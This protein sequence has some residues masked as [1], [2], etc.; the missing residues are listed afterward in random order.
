MPKDDLLSWTSS[1]ENI[2]KPPEL[3]QLFKEYPKTN[4]KYCESLDLHHG[5]I[6]RTLAAARRPPAADDIIAG[7]SVGR[8]TRVR[9]ENNVVARLLIDL[10]MDFREFYGFLRILEDWI[11]VFEVCHR[12]K[13][14]DTI[15]H[16]IVPGLWRAQTPS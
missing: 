8:I 3:D 1:T 10:P 6:N 2:R 11:Q 15:K 12:K 4:G 14:P 7:A 13:G 5:R 9:A 16:E